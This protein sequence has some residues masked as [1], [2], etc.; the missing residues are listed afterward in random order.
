MSKKLFRR[1]IEG[2]R[3]HDLFFQCN[4]DATCKI[5]FSSYQKRLAV[6]HMFPYGVVGD[7]VD[8]C[9]RMSESTCVD[10]MHKFYRAVI[11]VF[12]TV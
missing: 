2:V 4:M 10:S 3:Y 12:G 8:E 5:G 11:E 6:I 7:L 9:M 1:I